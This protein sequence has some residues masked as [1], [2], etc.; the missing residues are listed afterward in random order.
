MADAGLSLAV[1]LYQGSVVHFEWKLFST[2]NYCF[3]LPFFLFLPE[4]LLLNTADYFFVNF[5]YFIDKCEIYLYF[6]IGKII[7]NTKV[8]TFFVR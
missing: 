7:S 6:L 4:F 1:K 5:N 8:L 3:K 2:S